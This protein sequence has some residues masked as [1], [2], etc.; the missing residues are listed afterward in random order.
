MNRNRIIAMIKNYHWATLL[1]ILPTFLIMEIGLIFFAFKGGWLKEKI[2][3]Y[4]YFLSLKNWRYII[5]ARQQAQSLRQV[6][7]KDIIKLFSGKIWYQEI[8]EARLRIANVIFN[9][10]WKMIKVLIRW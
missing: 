9:I 7:D 10:Y 8:G 1:L 3:V 5:K 6:K 4:K 2:K